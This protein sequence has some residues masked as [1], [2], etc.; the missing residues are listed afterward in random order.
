[1][2][3]DA[4]VEL[5]DVDGRPGVWLTAPHDVFYVDRAGEWHYESARLSAQALVW[6]HGEV[7]LR[8]EG[9]FTLAEALAVARSVS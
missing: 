2:L 7:T 1:M 5:V 9:T 8:L 3:G 6:Q 4:Q